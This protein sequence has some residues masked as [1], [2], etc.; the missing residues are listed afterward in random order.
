MEYTY[1]IDISHYQGNIDFARVKASGVA[2]I[3]MKVSQKT[4]K[5]PRFEEY[6]AAAKAVG[7]P[8]GV[9]I[10]NKV[11][12]VTTAEQEASFAVAQ[13]RGKTLDLGVWLDME[14]SS[15]IPI[16]KRGL[17]TIINTEARVIQEAGFKVGIYCN[18]NWYQNVL[19]STALTPKY[20][21][22][23]ARYPNYPNDEVVRDGIIIAV[24]HRPSLGEVIASAR[25]N[26]YHIWQYSSKGH[27]DGIN[28]NV[29][30]NECNCDIIQMM[31]NVPPKIENVY[32]QALL[33]Q[34]VKTILG[35]TTVQE[36]FQKS[37]TLS[38]KYNRNNALVTPLERYLKE[39]G[40]YYGKIEADNGRYPIYGDGLAAAVMEYQKKVVKAK[41][42][43][44]DGIVTARGATWQK[45][46]G[47]S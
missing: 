35:V 23:I 37:I 16:G 13:L 2:F 28:G 26:Y 17:T 3:I 1:G 18:R 47:I 9:Y 42:Q 24:A 32:T 44:C 15:M 30:M 11:Y 34:D 31:S 19:D 22:W 46:L 4:W 36:A 25:P 43:H 38:K 21:F 8:V 40:Y 5:D 10:Y 20:P 27:I 41:P 7:I 39:L 12:D 45:L 14:D 29:D 6:Y 33:I